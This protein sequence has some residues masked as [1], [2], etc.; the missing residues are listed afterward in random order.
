MNDQL[1]MLRD[2]AGLTTVAEALGDEARGEATP[3]AFSAPRLGGSPEFPEPGIY[4]S[5]PDRD[6]HGIHAVSASGLKKL[7]VSSMDYWYYSSLNPERENDDT[8]AKSLG[9][10]YHA[11]ICEGAQAFSER[12]AV[13]LDK[14]DY[15]DALHTIAELRAACEERGFKAKGTKK[16][17]IAAQL[18][19][20]DPTVQIW[21]QLVAAWKDENDGKEPVRAV[22]HRRIEIAAKMIEADPQLCKAFTGG[23]PEVSIF[24]Y[25]RETGVPCK[26]RIDYLKMNAFV[27]LKSFSGRDRPVSREIDFAIAGQKTYIAVAFYTRA[28]AAAKDLIRRHGA[29]VV[30]GAADPAWFL[31]WAAVKDDPTPLYIWQK[32]GGAPVTRGRVMTRGTV[33]EVTDIHNRQLMRKW[34]RCAETYGAEMPWLDVAAIEQTVDESIPLS[35]TDFGENE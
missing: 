7:G 10:C 17:D 24:F 14:D 25:D 1:D 13:E 26:A 16:E 12:Y 29:S 5:M 9:R 34:R 21:D 22:D 6:Y 19:E 28:I 4:L 30:H 2:K 15:P 33:Y 27:D 20:A 11:R 8:A 23:F 32:V 18:L 31:K 3:S 35:A